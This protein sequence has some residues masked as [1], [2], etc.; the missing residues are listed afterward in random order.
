MAKSK[1]CTENKGLY[2][3]QLT[4]MITNDSNLK[5]VYSRALSH[6]CFGYVANNHDEAKILC[7]ISSPHII[8]IDQALPGNQAEELAMLF[9]REYPSAVIVFLID[10][11]SMELLKR[12]WGK[13]RELLEKPVTESAI[14]WIYEKYCLAPKK[15]VTIWHLANQYINQ[16][17]SDPELTEIKIAK[18]MN[19]N[20]TYFSR[21]FSNAV[22]KSFKEVLTQTRI[23]VAKQLLLDNNLQ[24]KEIARHV[25]YIHTA[26]FIRVFRKIAGETPSDYRKR[27]H[28][29]ANHHS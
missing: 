5:A 24:I 27:L 16:Q 15:G 23:G 29:I 17:Y 22:G 6:Q 1:S 26:S 4:L 9:H 13:V 18:I 2:C 12:L 8:Y 14:Q 10:K 19:I 11:I 3:N 7:Q 20:P 21:I 28:V 25:G